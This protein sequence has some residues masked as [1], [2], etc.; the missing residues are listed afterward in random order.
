LKYIKL[1]KRISK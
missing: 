1:A